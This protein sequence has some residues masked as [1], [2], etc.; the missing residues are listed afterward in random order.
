V[1]D[2][3]DAVRYFPL[4]LRYALIA[5]IGS[6][7]IF[8]ERPR[9]T[10]F[11]PRQVPDLLH[12]TIQRLDLAGT[13]ALNAAKRIAR[14]LSQ[15]HP[16]GRC[17]STHLTAALQAI[18]RHCGGCCSDYAQVFVG[19]CAAAGIGAREWGLCDGF[20]TMN[21]GHCFN[22]VYSAEHRKWVLIDPFLSVYATSHETE[23]PLGVTELVDKVAG[24]RA[25]DV[26]FHWIDG[27]Q[28]AKAAALVSQYY[29]G[30]ENLFFLTGNYNVF[31]EDRLLRAGGWLPVSLLHSVLLLLGRYHR[32][33]LYTNPL[34]RFR[35]EREMGAVKTLRYVAFGH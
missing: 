18:Q 24:G 2:V 6:T 4:R 23:T 26:Q 13:D 29:F 33:W 16:R 32:F 14:Y 10:F 20:T 7:R 9:R 15:G 3:T 30:R 31:E 1:T 5:R 22:E 25:S 12:D 27:T 35:V 8:G 34:N 28:E 19:L 17:L 21:Y 11:R